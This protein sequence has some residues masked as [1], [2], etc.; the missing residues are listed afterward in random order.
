[1]CSGQARIAFL[2]VFLLMLLLRY[3]GGYCYIRYM[4]M[5]NT[6]LCENNHKI[7]K[8]NQLN[9]F[10]ITKLSLVIANFQRRQE[11]CDAQIE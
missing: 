6:I 3:L 1:M 2:F 5:S 10:L 8:T 7:T 9:Y 11:N 4:S